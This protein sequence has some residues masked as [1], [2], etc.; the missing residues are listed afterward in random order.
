MVSISYALLFLVTMYVYYNDRIEL[1]LP[2]KTFQCSWWCFLGLVLLASLMIGDKA[3]ILAAL[4]YIYLSIPFWL[5]LFF[6]Q[7]Y[8]KLEAFIMGMG[9]SMLMVGIKSLYVFCAIN[10]MGMGRVTAFDENR[11]VFATLLITSLPF[12]CILV[13]KYWLSKKGLAIF[14]LTSSVF[15]IVALILTGSRGGMVGFAL[16]CLLAVLFKMVLVNWR[17]NVKSL[18]LGLAIC[19]IIIFGFVKTQGNFQRHYDTQRFLFWE[20]S[21]NMWREHKFIGVG[22]TNWEKA[23]Y[24]QYRLPQAYEK[25]IGVPHNVIFFYFST[26]GIMGGIGYIGFL[27]GLIWYL[28]KKL[29]AQ[30]DNLLIQAMLWSLM[31]ITVHGMVDTGIQARLVFRLFSAYM[32]V[33]VASILLTEHGKK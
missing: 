4:D 2:D 1:L 32:G 6:Y 22:I 16:G 3:C 27:F 19:L 7:R 11:N 26:T 25:G 13:R 29:K 23:Y 20:S 31:A 33:T 18:I 9:I 15:G 28:A 10:S 17:Q 5:L 8:P 12:V 30:P 21:Y 24:E 14:L